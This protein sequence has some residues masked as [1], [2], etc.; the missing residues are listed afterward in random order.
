MK[1]TFTKPGLAPVELDY[2][3]YV[4]VFHAMKLLGSQYI[5]L[6]QWLDF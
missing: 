6:A 3:G 1:V 2:T 5:I 4:K